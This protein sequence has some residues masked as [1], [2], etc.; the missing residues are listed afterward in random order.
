MLLEPLYLNL[1]NCSF[2]GSVY[3]SVF[4]RKLSPFLKRERSDLTKHIDE[5]KMVKLSEQGQ[6]LIYL[7]HSSAFGL[8]ILSEYD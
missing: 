1:E 4:S 6:G 3:I 7:N 2:F 8:L 5:C